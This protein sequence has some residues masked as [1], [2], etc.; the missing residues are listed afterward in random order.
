M[1]KGWDRESMSP[2]IIH[3]MLVPKK[4]GT[5]RMYT[6]YKAINNIIIK[7]RHIIPQLDDL[8]EKLYGS[9][10]LLKNRL[11]SGYNHI[12]VKEGDERKTTFKTEFG[13]YE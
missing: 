11:K 5:W 2:C 10:V 12:R 3:V 9:S 7:N 13:L 8:I 4:D 6:D 1:D